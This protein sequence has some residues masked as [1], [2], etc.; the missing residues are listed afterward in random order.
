MKG[1]LQKLK[2]ANDIFLANGTF[3]A[4]IVISIAIKKVFAQHL[5]FTCIFVSLHREKTWN[6]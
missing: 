4:V 2:E 5:H 3:Q 1:I 6:H